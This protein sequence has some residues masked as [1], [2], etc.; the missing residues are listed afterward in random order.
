MREERIQVIAYEEPHG[1]IL[2]GSWVLRSEIEAV[3]LEV[4]RRE[5]EREWEEFKAT[6]A[7]GTVSAKPTIS[8]RAETTQKSKTDP[9]REDV[10]ELVKAE[11]Y[12][13]IC[14][15]YHQLAK[16]D[17]AHTP[18]SVVLDARR[19]RDEALAKV[20]ALMGV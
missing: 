12:L 1:E 14:L 4:Y 18:T 15:E 17:L 11:D 6:C 13:F 9:F 16:D 3:V 5:R 2:T 20:R 19:Q 10:R 7:A 8:A